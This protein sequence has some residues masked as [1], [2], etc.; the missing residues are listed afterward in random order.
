M[1]GLS[2]DTEQVFHSIKNLALLNEYIL[3]G[4]TA[5]SLQINHRLSEDLDFCKWQDDN[6]LKYL[7]IRWHE[8]EKKLEQFGTLK[9]DILDFYQVNFLLNDVKISF[10]SNALASFGEVK[11]SIAYKHIR[12]A[13]IRSLGTM[14]LEVMSRRYQFR[15]YYDVYSILL[16][17]IS[18][19]E[20]VSICGKYSRHRM[21]SKMILG[22]LSNGSLFK[23]E[24]NFELLEPKYMVTSEDIEVYMRE[25]I[26]KEYG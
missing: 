2:K 3:I 14:K 22:I 7:E 25:Q 8:I 4:G 24:E 16:E 6:R 15:D 10:Y 9:T 23:Q 26:R 20:M 11:T 17:G 18:L 5:L 13:D 19:K 1:K 21:K 12:L